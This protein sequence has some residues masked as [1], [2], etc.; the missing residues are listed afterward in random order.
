MLS[1]WEVLLTNSN[2]ICS[3]PALYQAA[4]QHTI[5]AL[6]ARLKRELLEIAQEIR[7][8]FPLAASVLKQV[9]QTVIVKAEE[10]YGNNIAQLPEAVQRVGLTDLDKFF[11]SL[12]DDLLLTNSTCL[13]NEIQA[14]RTLA[15]ERAL[16]IMQSG[17][18][19]SFIVASNAALNLLT[20]QLKDIHLSGDIFDTVVRDVLKDLKVHLNS[21]VE[22]SSVCE[23]MLSALQDC[24]V[25]KDFGMI[26]EHCK[27]F[28]KCCDP[29]Y[30][31]KAAAL[32]AS[33][34]L[35]PIKST[36]GL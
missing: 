10:E 23:A 18:N 12:R 33:S 20:K 25:A 35:R 5:D 15:I 32:I 21:T 27:F 26:A 17:G 22:T 29:G 31:V 3:L 24:I 6:T 1:L 11:S 4:D 9:L 13:I 8:R 36:A 16:S 14:A 30:Q 2:T 19:N 28:L 7:E 34:K